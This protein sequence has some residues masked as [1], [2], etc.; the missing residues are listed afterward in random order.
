MIIARSIAEIAPPE[1]RDMPRLSLVPRYATACIVAACFAT[2]GLFASG[3][4]P[5]EPTGKAG[6]ATFE[7]ESVDAEGQPIERKGFIWYP[8]SETPVAHNYGGQIGEAA[9]DA[10]VAEGRWPTIVFSHGFLGSGDQAIFLMEAF[11]RAGYIVAACDHADAHF[12]GLDADADPPK[13]GDGKNWTDA[14]FADRRRDM[15]KL[16]DWTL[17]RDQAPK[18]KLFE[19][20]DRERI[21]AAGHSLGGY[22]CLGLAGAWPS[23]K[24]DRVRAVLLYSPYAIPWRENGVAS[25]V[26]VPAMIQG[27]TLDLSVTPMLVPVFHAFSGPAYAVVLKQEN[28]FGWTNLATLG[29]TTR[30]AEAT[31]NT[32][33]MCEYGIAFFDRHLRGEPIT[34]DDL[35]SRPND[36]VSRFRVRNVGE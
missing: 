28:H 15:Q 26:S 13:F 24:D 12:H 1:T 7:L 36:E 33:W 17:A 2:S 32:K 29:R 19:H 31:G 8:T 6:F 35:L 14:K 22:T 25:R 27:G 3:N 21:G 18:S 30:Q 11:A 20:V 23:W 16:I 9:P 5:P 4:E 34:D 10:K